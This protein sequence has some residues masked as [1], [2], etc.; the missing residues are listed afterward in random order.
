VPG[1]TILGDDIAYLRLVGGRVRAVNVEKGM[2]GIID[3]VNS[4]HDPLIW[5]VLRNPGEVI[6]SNILV[7]EGGRSI[8]TAWTV[9]VRPKG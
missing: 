6:F 4:L 5:K 1:E 2:F 9:S 8:G 3:G 7:T